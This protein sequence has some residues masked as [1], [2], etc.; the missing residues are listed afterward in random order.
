M[1]RLRFALL[2]AAAAAL[3]FAAPLAAAEKDTLVFSWSSILGDMNPHMY[4]PNQPFGQAMIFEPLVRY[5]DDGT[6]QPCLAESWEISDDGKT[7]VFRLRKGVLFSD[8]EPWNANAAKK[9]FDAIMGNA[10]RHAWMG[11]TDQYESTSIMDEHTLKLTLKNAY[12]PA[13]HDLSTIRPF[14]F[15]SPTAF[16]ADGDTSKGILKGVGTGPWIRVETKKGEYDLFAR[17]DLYWGK[18]PAFKQV[19]VKTIP[20]NE[21]R[22]I[23]L[24]TGD[25]DLIC[26]ASGQGAAQISIEA[27]KRLEASG[28]FTTAVSGPSATRAVAINSGCGAT[29]DIA[30]RKAIQ[31]A[32]DKDLLISAVFQNVEKR[33]DFLFDPRFP[34]CDA[35]L[36]PY[37][38]DRA[39]AEKIL[40]D[41]GWKKSAESEYRS[42]N[43][44]ELVVELCFIGNDPLAKTVA[45]VLQSDLRKIGMKLV[46]IGEENDSIWK[47]QKDGEF[48][49]VF[50]DT[51]GA[52]FEP[53][54]MIAS[55][56]LPS[57]ADYQAQSG[58]PMKTELDDA[59]RSVLLTTDEETRRGMYRDILGTL[60]DQAVYLCLTYKTMLKVHSPKLDGVDFTPIVMVV[61]FERMH[62]KE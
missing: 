53:H 36:T 37:M 4:L 7:Y 24:E 48:G 49:M 6:I 38:L 23:A 61:P 47:R 20:E 17:N 52:P 18:K 59:I 56:L 26:G 40:D 60:H 3:L 1:K 42:K 2:A 29:A 22:V 12:Y 21:S 46:L 43:G 13:L 28:R 32:V 16:P 19:L 34:Y 51:W 27:F 8:G 58:L 44:E 45:E 30:V 9:N 33:A 15:L 62:W 39:L 55:M 41:A 25:I 14:R 10:K 31:H 35:D 57:H 50:N 54:A 11:F 5:G